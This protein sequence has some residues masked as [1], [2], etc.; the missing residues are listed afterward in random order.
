MSDIASD[1]LIERL[2]K[3]NEIL[4]EE[5]RVSR[6][7]ADITADLVVQQFAKADEMLMELEEKADKEKHLK[8]Q[9]EDQLE[10]AVRREQELNQ[11]KNRLR[12]MQIASINMMEDLALS[13]QIAEAATLAKSEFL[14]NMS[15]EIR[16]PMNGVIGM[17]NLLLDTP[18]G[19]EQVEFAE[20]IKS[21]ADS[22]LRII[23]D[24]LDFSKI[25]AGKLELEI[26]DFDLRGTLDEVG[27]LMALKAH[28]KGLEFVSNIHRHVPLFL[29]GDPGRLRQ[30]LINL[31]G[32][33]VKFTEKGE[34][35]I[36]VSLEENNRTH[37]TIRFEIIDTGIGIP[38]DRME[39]LFKP[40]SQ[41]DSSSTRE[42]SGTGLGLTISK[43]LSEMMGGRIGVESRERKGSKFWFTAVFE[44][45]PERSRKR[46]ILPGDIRNK[47]ILIVDDNA[48]NRHVLREQLK[49]WGCKFNEASS[50]EEALKKMRQKIDG[51]H[52]F[53]LAILDMQ[54]PGMDGETLGRKIKQD[55][56]LK[57]TILVLMTS[58][59]KRGDARR[60]EKIGFA[61]YLT[62]PVK[63]SQLFDC[64]VTVS[65]LGNETTSEQP[66]SIFTRHTIFEKQMRT[67]R[68]LLAE[69]NITN[70][71]VALNTLKKFGYNADVVKNG[72]E[73]LEAI[74][75]ISYDIVLMD[76]Q[77][78]VMDGYEATNEIRKWEKTLEHGTADR[79]DSNLESERLKRIPIIAMTAHALKG[80]RE[81]CID[82]GMND[83]IAKPIHPKKLYDVIEKW[84]NEPEGVHEP[85]IVHESLPKNDVFDK[86]SFIDRLLGDEDLAKEIIKGF[87]EDSLRQIN[88]LKEA[89]DSK[90]ADVIHCHA[91]SLKGAAA[92]IS[93]TVL[94]ELA[95]Q[96]EIAGQTKDLIKAASLVPKLDEQFEV[97]KK[98]FSVEIPV[99]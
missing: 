88:I 48:T 59:G 46:E 8:D 92:N 40:F 71:K 78:P 72:K 77:M 2:R 85:E 29:L 12:D 3:E 23:N 69:D 27:D 83:Y 42:F 32:N 91:H 61:G 47:Y 56:D 64:L 50:G 4:R 54:M 30:I 49:S 86:N 26:I 70:Q 35:A 87:I 25:E 7:A 15:H 55:S 6:K 97:L 34:I 80:D 81:K 57:N 1:I 96:I 19:A 63:Q 5:I 66:M 36:H 82:A 60:L 76:C 43:Q 21:S 44:K 68:I 74:K 22:L 39:Q 67:A 16:T 31:I 10:K 93:A 73:A 13:Q 28:E 90:D 9:V 95:Y 52:P 99:K 58:I 84:V 45:Q 89:V 53:D 62:K 38:N 11:E 24:I 98:R 33:A 18:L 65:G 51:N 75:K 79:S 17:A 37:A 41:I 14:A 94:K 20:T